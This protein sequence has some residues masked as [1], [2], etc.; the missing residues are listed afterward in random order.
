M[1]F[2]FAQ[3]DTLRESLTRRLC[4]PE[5]D[6]YRLR[7]RRLPMPREGLQLH[8]TFSQGRGVQAP[9]R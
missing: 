5:V 1:S 8:V 6:G 3:D 7:D 4:R 2:D 9:K